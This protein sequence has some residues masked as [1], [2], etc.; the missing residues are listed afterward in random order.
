V[1]EVGVC[2]WS[3]RPASPRELAR[4]VLSCGV[5]AVQLALDPLRT[6]A[7]SEPELLAEFKANHIRILSGMM[8][9]VGEDYS[10]L[11]TIRHTGGLRP[12]R[13][14]PAN[15]AA[16]HENAVLAARL[17][18][19]LVTLHAG[20]LPHGAADPL[21]PVMIQRLREV[22]RAFAAKGIRVAFETGQEDARTLLDVLHEL[23]AENPGV[24]FDPA[25][26]ILYGMGDPL[27]AFRELAPHV[28]QVHIKD[29]TPPSRPGEWGEEVVVGTG[30]I[31]WTRFFD[32]IAELRPT[33]N[34][35][36]EREAGESRVAD[37]KIARKLVMQIGGV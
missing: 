29:A 11:D 3:L 35:L 31:D 8:T 21:R 13:H 20:F 18:L 10:T 23:R 30:S 14:W 5:D 9:T 28:V 34:L 37:I 26:M 2:S 1:P 33:V 6:G 22:L 32:T 24:N 17:G 19:N 16:A 36:I 4:D 15:L 27:A 12:D 7:W 25:N